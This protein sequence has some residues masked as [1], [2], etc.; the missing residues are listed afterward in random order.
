MKSGSIFFAASSELIQVLRHSFLHSFLQVPK[1]QSQFFSGILLWIYWHIL[2]MSKYIRPS[3]DQAAANS[4]MGTHL[5]IEYVGI[6]MIGLVEICIKAWYLSF[7]D[8]YPKVIVQKWLGWFRWIFA[9]LSRAA[10]FFLKRA[11]L[12]ASLPNKQCPKWHCANT[13][14][15]APE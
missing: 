9:N 13:H 2:I 8:F 4:H 6:H 12:P 3:F 14:L 10:I 11:H 7:G 1:Q 15:Y 5:T